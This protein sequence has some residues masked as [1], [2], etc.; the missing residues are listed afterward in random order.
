MMLTLAVSTI[1]FPSSPKNF[2]AFSVALAFFLIVGVERKQQ[3]LILFVYLMPFIS[4][5]IRA[6]RATLPKFN[7][8]KCE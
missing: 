4:F 5:L 8:V 2:S 1:R 6:G 3:I 7:N